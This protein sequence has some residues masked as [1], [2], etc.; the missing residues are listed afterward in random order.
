MKSALPCPLA[1]LCLKGNT[2]FDFIIDRIGIRN[3]FHRNAGYHVMI[4]FRNIEHD[5][6]KDF[7]KGRPSEIHLTSSEVRAG[8]KIETSLVFDQPLL[9]LEEKCSNKVCKFIQRGTH[10]KVF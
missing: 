6:Y 8:S 3:T 4:I 1:N 2:K 10:F 9:G 5:L 7:S